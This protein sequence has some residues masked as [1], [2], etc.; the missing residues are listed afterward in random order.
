[1]IVIDFKEQIYSEPFAKTLHILIEN[2]IDLSAFYE[3]YDNDAGGR[4]AYDP[5]MMLKIILFS[6][7]KGIMSSRDMAWHCKNNII[8]RSLCCD[9]SPHFTSIAS[10]ISSYPEHIESVFEQV[11]LVCDDEDLLGHELIAIDGCKMSSNAAKEHSGTF[12]ELT[13]KREKIQK[14]IRWCLTEH[15]KL[16]ARRPNE[17][18]RKAQLKQE[19]ETLEK[20]FNK[21]DKFL[22]TEQPRMGKAKK[23]KE[24]KSN[25]TDNESAKMTTSKMSKQQGI[26]NANSS[27]T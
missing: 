21:I 1:M 4:K 16:D 25:M 3:N 20:Q 2:H 7:Y 11:L 27:G 22:K 19:A 17:K 26:Q 9:H 8:L 13:N 18:D 14:K 24:V 6:Y 23:P 15:K 12:K 5:A 10:F